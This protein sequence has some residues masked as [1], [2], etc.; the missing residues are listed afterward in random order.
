MNDD[1]RR[2]VIK[3]LA[4]NRHPQEICEVMNVPRELV[5]SISEEEIAAKCEELRRKGYVK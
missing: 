1:I 3:A 5:D 2:E 4:Y